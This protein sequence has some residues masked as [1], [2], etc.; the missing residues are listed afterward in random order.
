[1]LVMSKVL[2]ETVH[3]LLARK[4]ADDGVDLGTVTALVSELIGLSEEVNRVDGETIVLVSVTS[5]LLFV[6][7]V[8]FELICFAW[9]AGDATKA[10]NS[11][12]HLLDFPHV[13]VGMKETV[14]FNWRL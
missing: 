4:L 7:C 14:G 10:S 8:S 3:R 13:G 11:F 9:E 12:D 1:M 2:L 5:F 6:G